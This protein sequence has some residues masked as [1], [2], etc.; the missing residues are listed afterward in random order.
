MAKVLWREFKKRRLFG[1]GQA[2][3]DEAIIAGFGE[4]RIGFSTSI[5]PSTTAAKTGDEGGFAAHDTAPPQ[6]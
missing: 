5:G 2:L 6:L 3:D 4:V 1:L